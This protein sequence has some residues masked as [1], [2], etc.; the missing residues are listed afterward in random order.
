MATAKSAQKS[1][2]EKTMERSAQKSAKFK[3]LAVKRTNKALKAI[4]GIE[5]LSNRNSYTYDDLQVKKITTALQAAVDAV[6][7]SFKTPDAKRTGG[8]DL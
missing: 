1:P 3:E 6:V 7:N 2:Q 5:N 4:S 8:F